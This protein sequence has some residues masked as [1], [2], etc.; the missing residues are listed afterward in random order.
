MLGMTVNDD[1]MLK[2]TRIM[3]ENAIPPFDG[4]YLFYFWD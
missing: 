1:F 3:P 4:G 2:I